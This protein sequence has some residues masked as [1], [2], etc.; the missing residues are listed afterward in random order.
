[1]SKVTHYDNKLTTVTGMLIPKSRVAVYSRN[2]PNVAIECMAFV[3]FL[4]GGYKGFSVR[5]PTILPGIF[6]GYPWSSQAN[7]GTA[8]TT[9]LHTLANSLTIV[10]FTW[11]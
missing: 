3:L 7:A 2:T 10:H 6:L 11:M 5:R 8:T 4:G 1:M 9:S